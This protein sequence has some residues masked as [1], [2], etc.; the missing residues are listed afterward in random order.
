MS[1]SLQPHGLQHARLPCPLLSPGVCSS[2]CPLSRWCYPTISSSVT[3]FS[4]CLQSFPTSG[5]FPMSWLSAFSE[6]WGGQTIG[7]SALASVLPMNTQNWSPLGWTRWISLQSKHP[8]KANT[9][10]FTQ[11]VI[12]FLFFFHIYGASFKYKIIICRCISGIK[13]PNY[14]KRWTMYRN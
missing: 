5:S 6:I 10:G 3:L 1:N 8:T 11:A 9:L 7:T 14:D 13:M 4:F 12:V 2:S